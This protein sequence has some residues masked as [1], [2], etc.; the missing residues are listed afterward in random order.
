M[1]LPSPTQRIIY[2]PGLDT[3]RAIAFLMIFFHHSLAF[4]DAKP[5]LSV[6]WLQYSLVICLGMGVPL[7]F[8]LS[9]FLLSR[10]LIEEKEATG[11]VSIGN[12]Y[13]RRTLRIWP[14]YFLVVA[15][16]YV[17]GSRF[18]TPLEPNVLQGLALFYF[19]FQAAAHI[20]APFLV[21]P[22]WSLCVEEQFYVIWPNLLRWSSRRGL[23]WIGAFLVFGGLGYR[24][25]LVGQGGDW[26]NGW[27]SS[28][29]HLDSF[30]LGAILAAYWEKVPNFPTRLRWS[31]FGYP[32]WLVMIEALAPSR[33]QG[34]PI[35]LPGMF[36]Y[37]VVA[38]LSA[39]AV[40]ACAQATDGILTNRILREIGKRSYS[41]YCLHGV[42][43]TLAHQILGSQDRTLKMFALGLVLNFG[44]GFLS[45]EY[46]ERW[47]LRLKQRFQIVRSGAPAS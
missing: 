6:A 28:F 22:L 37:L 39:G 32:I 45:F 31:V 16:S 3:L 10:L 34:L 23:A 9:A 30:G 13:I 11:T 26:K 27:F 14:L 15:I 19:N 43:F 44:L 5:S 21:G 24:I 18:Q 20:P 8:L 17:L 40:W 46:Y 42:A 29:Y 47:F 33:P 1:S 41:L 2:Y 25:W 36:A 4:G 38:C 12:F 7:F 35:A